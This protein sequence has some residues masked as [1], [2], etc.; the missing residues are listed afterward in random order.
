MSP[1]GGNTAKLKSLAVRF[2]RKYVKAL[3]FMGASQGGFDK[4]IGL[5]LESVPLADPY[6]LKTEESLPVRVLLHGQSR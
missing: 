2:I 1:G 6:Q 5:T 3:G 4:P